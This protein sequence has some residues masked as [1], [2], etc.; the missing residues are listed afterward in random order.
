MD[1][2]TEHARREMRD[3][4][5]PINVDSGYT[6]VRTEELNYQTIEVKPELPGVT[7]DDWQRVES[8][9]TEVNLRIVQ[10]MRNDFESANSSFRG[11]KSSSEE[12][13][14]TVDAYLSACLSRD[15]G[16][17]ENDTMMVTN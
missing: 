15:G 3:F 16:N 9:L 10:E 17:P 5:D 1:Q 11:L 13:S 7:D 4:D 12:A 8:A 2:V 14:S 6:F